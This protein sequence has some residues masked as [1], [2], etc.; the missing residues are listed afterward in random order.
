[1]EYSNKKRAWA[2]GTL[3]FCSKGR[4]W[5][6]PVTL[7]S[8]GSHVCIP[9]NTKSGNMTDYTS[10]LVSVG[11]LDV[12]PAGVWSC[13]HLLHCTQSWIWTVSELKI[14]S[15]LSAATHSVGLKLT[16]LL[17]LHMKTEM[18]AEIKSTLTLFIHQLRRVVDLCFCG[19][20]VICCNLVV[21]W[22]T[23]I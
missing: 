23:N 21:Q 13:D 7:P 22:K 19:P 15:F 20:V 2:Q 11:S 6:L 16:W 10:L 12:M 8:N 14:C 18:R 5:T 4:A 17:M 1:M 9:C 3:L